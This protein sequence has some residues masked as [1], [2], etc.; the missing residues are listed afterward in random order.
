[1]ARTFLFRYSA[2]ALPGLV[3][4]ATILALSSCAKLRDLPSGEEIDQVG[5]IYPHTKKA[6]WRDEHVG[7]YLAIHAPEEPGEPGTTATQAEVRATGHSD[8]Q[9]QICISCHKLQAKAPRALPR[10]LNVT[11][12]ASCHATRPAGEGKA[13]SKLTPKDNA[14]TSCHD[15]DTLFPGRQ[16]GF[17][18][19]I[20]ANGLC[21][22]CHQTKAEHPGT[23]TVTRDPNPE[24]CLRCHDFKKR[25][26][27]THDPLADMGGCI[28]C[29]DPHGSEREFMV[30]DDTPGL[31]LNCHST[32]EGKSVHGVVSSG[33]NCM[34]CH[35]PHSPR[36]QGLLRQA[37]P[38]LCL[39]CHNKKMKVSGR[40]IPD[41]QAQVAL[42]SAHRTNT[43]C[44]DCHK[45]HASSEDRLLSARYS[46][47]DYTQYTPGDAENPNTYALCFG[48]HDQSMLNRDIFT[49]NETAF[50][51]GTTNLHWFHVTNE[52]GTTGPRFGRSCRNCHDPHGA[53]QPRLIR[54][55][56]GPRGFP[57]IYR[58]TPNGG[59]CTTYCHSSEHPDY[60]RQGR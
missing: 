34:N 9:K 10:A 23:D 58:V 35:S 30:R 29:H 60:S 27:G 19:A 20:A 32:P 13:L 31:C 16:K 5:E 39:S 47:K 55:E 43:S 26:M 56:T 28:F 21:S 36:A 6:K 25:G 38:E 2:F 33:K 40:T 22:I 15:A 49:G 52:A 53:K 7:Y 57:L 12:G 18:H 50:R 1:M 59:N 37:A 48:C 3:A 41:I 11:C 51:N 46:I 24:S 17:S 4:L 54:S 14:C 44:R 8:K 42:P 45:P